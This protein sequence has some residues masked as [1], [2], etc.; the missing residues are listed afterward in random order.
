MTVLLL[1]MGWQPSARHS[2]TEYY[3]I[4]V[5]F[6]HILYLLISQKVEIDIC[7]KMFCHESQDRSSIWLN[8]SYLIT[9]YPDNLMETANWTYLAAGYS[10][11]TLMIFIN[12]ERYDCL[13]AHRGRKHTAYWFYKNILETI[14]WKMMCVHVAVCVHVQWNHFT[15]EVRHSA[16]A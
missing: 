6:H 5:H 16:K 13:L 12:A 8:S 2:H 9:R 3:S 4:T 7:I 10:T 11:Q 14:F 15:R 1:C